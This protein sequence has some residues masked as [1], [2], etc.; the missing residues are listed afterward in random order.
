MTWQ[1]PLILNNAGIKRYMATENTPAASIHIL[2]VGSALGADQ[3]G[4]LAVHALDAAAFRERHPDRRID[5]DVCLSPALLAAQCTS[6]QPLILLDAY[7]SDEP[8]AT[9][10]RISIE[11]LETV[12]RPASSHGFDIRQALALSQVLNGENPPV[13][14][15]GICVGAT[16]GAIDC[17]APGV[18][19]NRALP[20]LLRTIDHTIRHW[21]PVGPDRHD[22]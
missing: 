10:R 15:I 17:P 8:P 1:G 21:P 2:G 20:A 14:V 4:I 5:I 7:C 11:E 13:S 6:G 12:Q 16:P 9:V 19:L 22:A 18:I 3:L